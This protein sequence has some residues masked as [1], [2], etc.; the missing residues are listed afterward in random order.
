MSM[1]IIG[2]S[3]HPKKKKLSR[4]IVDACFHC[5]WLSRALDEMCLIV[6]TWRKKNNVSYFLQQ[7]KEKKLTKGPDD[8]DNKV[9]RVFVIV[10]FFPF[11][12]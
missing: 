9:S 7:T 10:A 11:F 6:V 3:L 5:R 1:Y 2:L 12:M 8:D 4:I